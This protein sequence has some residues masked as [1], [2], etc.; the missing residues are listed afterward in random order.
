MSRFFV[1]SKKSHHFHMGNF[2]IGTINPPAAEFFRQAAQLVQAAKRDF[3]SLFLLLLQ[4]SL[5]IL[6]FYRIL[7]DIV[8]YWMQNKSCAA[9][10]HRIGFLSGAGNSIFPDQ[11]GFYKE[12]EA[13]YVL[14]CFRHHF[15]HCLS[16][17]LC[18]SDR[19]QHPC[20]PYFHP[21]VF[22]KCADR[23]LSDH[24]E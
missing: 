20:N 8:L 13:L 15:R 7:S 3:I 19:M 17:N 10:C 6:Q 14:E 21:G 4:I 9:A 16:D 18:G 2:T 22:N 1:W 24:N 11:V 12:M 23:M 5:L